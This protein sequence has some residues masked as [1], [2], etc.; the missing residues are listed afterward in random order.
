MRNLSNDDL[1][2]SASRGLKTGVEN[3]I[4]WSEIGSA[5]RQPGGTP[6]QKNPRSTPSGSSLLFFPCLFLYNLLLHTIACAALIL[7][8]SFRDFVR[9]SY[10]E[11]WDSSCEKS[12]IPVQNHWAPV[13]KTTSSTLKMFGSYVTRQLHIENLKTDSKPLYHSLLK[14]IYNP[15]NENE[16]TKINMHR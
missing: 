11:S 1:V 10:G 4:F 8:N 6:R 12:W 13:Q 14:L 5:F 16:G 9:S 2:I 3:D 15:H 7:R